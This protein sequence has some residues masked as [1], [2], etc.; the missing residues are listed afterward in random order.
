MTIHID[1]DSRT[2]VVAIP[3][4]R[5]ATPL[6]YP[7]WSAAV[8]YPAGALVSHQNVIWLARTATTIEPS[9]SA[10]E[11]SAYLDGRPAEAARQAAEAA[12][13]AA[14]RYQT[15]VVADA[16]YTPGESAAGSHVAFT[17][18]TPVMMIL[19]DTLSLGWNLMGVQAGAGAVTLVPGAGV[20]LVEVQNRLTTAGP[21]AGFAV[22]RAGDG[23]FYAAGD[24]VV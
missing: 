1:R 23:V 8:S 22:I 5:Q 20:S 24:V 3:I 16:S 15:L 19:T 12:A 21:G 4:G 11:W 10:L 7:A 17:A 14:A 6:L 18:A 9:D 13:T 2:E